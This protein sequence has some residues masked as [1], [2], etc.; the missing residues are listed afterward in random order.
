MKTKLLFAFLFLTLGFTKAQIITT[1]AG[2]GFG[3]PS[4]GGYSGDG[5]QATNAEFYFPFSLSL[6]AGGN[7]YVADA[8]NRVIRKINTAGIITT[9]AGGGFNGLGD[10]GQ[11]TAAN[12][13]N[14][15]QAFFDA[16]GNM[17]IVDNGHNRIRLVSTTGIISTIAGNGQTGFGGDGGPATAAKLHGPQYVTFDASGNLY[18]ADVGN[19]RIRKINT[20]GIIS[21]IAG[22]GTAG[23]SGDGG[24]ATA[25]KLN[26]PDGVT[27]DTN[28]NLYVADYS[29]NRIRMV[30]TAGII[31]T[32]VG[33][34]VAGFSGDGGQATVAQINGPNDG[35]V[36]DALGN[37][38]IPDALNNCVRKVNT[39]GIISTIAGT[40]TAG[41]SGDGGSALAAELNYPGGVALDSSLCNLYI[42]DLYNNRIR[43]VSNAEVTITV[44]SP[45]VCIGNTATLIATGAANYTWTPNTNLNTNLGS[46]VVTT[47]TTNTTYSVL[48]TVGS[49]HNSATALVTINQLPIITVTTPTICIGD[50]GTLTASGANT[51][52]W[53]TGA[54]TSSIVVGPA[55]SS[56]YTVV[57]VNATNCMSVP[58]IA[59]IIVSPF[60]SVLISGN[61]NICTGENTTLIASGASTYTW[62]TGDTLA[63]LVVSHP[64]NTSYTVTG[65][66]GTCSTKTVTSVTV[67]NPF[68][69]TMPNIV[70]PNN[71]GVNDYI[72]FG[73]YQFSSI[74]LEIYNRWGAKVFESSNPA[75]IWKPTEDD[76][77]YFYTLQSQISC[78]SEKQN[79]TLKGFITVIK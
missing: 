3:A 64:I 16:T 39:L 36:F 55:T 1:I 14:P 79:K 7:I 34:R 59:A 56:N 15:T 67:N 29:N 76:G 22:T 73:N 48:S 20:T 40:G 60:P 61:N 37:F 31:N 38:Y 26:G 11:A 25:A 32:I 13:W 77:T 42:A 12:L 30:N 35:I 21:T 17:Y 45:S 71:D 9:V 66:F 49:C 57:G 47:N 72:D 63:N 78:N 2:N 58:T 8:Y 51:Y 10:G 65:A 54:N 74:Q 5:G 75:C 24:Q 19:N 33:T 53:S 44:N 62:S 6:D 28:G 41:F 23:F 69:F 27:F 4:N 43:V 50:T 52:T 18:I 68:S 70:T 46:T